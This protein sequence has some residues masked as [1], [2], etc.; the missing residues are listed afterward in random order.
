MRTFFANSF[1]LQA[2]MLDWMY[3]EERDAV[4][5]S[6]GF[7]LR[8]VSQQDVEQHFQITDG[9]YGTIAA[10]LHRLQLIDGRRYVTT[11]SRGSESSASYYTTMSLTDLGTSVIIACSPLEDPNDPKG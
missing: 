3:Y 6:C 9:T 11:R 2:K 7:R 8:D 1:R 5:E 4:P 10:D